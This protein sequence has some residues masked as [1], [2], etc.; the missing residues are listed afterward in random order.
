MSR[1]AL[2]NPDRQR[3]LV[4]VEIPAQVRVMLEPG[5][6]AYRM[7]GCHIICSQQKAGWHLTISRL[8][9]LPSWEEVRDVRYQLIP[10]EATMAMLLPP[11]TEYV[12]VH[13]FCLQLYEIPGEYITEH[14]DRL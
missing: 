14:Q 1:G 3:Q 8:D 6:K 10:D 4:E 12:N 11:R 5:S 13:P 2:R 7:G 9:K